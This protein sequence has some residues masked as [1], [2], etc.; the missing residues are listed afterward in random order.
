MDVVLKKV[1]TWSF[2]DI[3]ENYLLYKD[4]TVNP[5]LTMTTWLKNKINNGRNPCYVKF[6][7]EILTTHAEE[8]HSQ[9]ITEGGAP[10]SFKSIL[11]MTEGEYC[12]FKRYC[13]KLN[14]PLKSLSVD[15]NADCLFVK[16]FLYN[17]RNKIKN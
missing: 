10:R 2:E 11:S 3:L 17:R 16:N 14:K 5:P 6:L 8:I 4:T 15:D 13:K 7:Q 9:R 12:A 1:I